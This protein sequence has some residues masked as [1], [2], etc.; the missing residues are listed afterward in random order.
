M[1]ANQLPSYARPAGGIDRRGM[2]ELL[3]A[4]RRTVTTLFRLWRQRRR[5]RQE[6]ARLDDRT[7][8][9]IGL[10]GGDAEFLINK[11]FWRG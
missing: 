11:P 2:L 7:L 1:R 9:D 6:L 5:T 4:G 8:R 3:H 10:T